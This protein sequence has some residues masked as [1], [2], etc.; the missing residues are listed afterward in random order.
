MVEP[1]ENLKSK[2]EKLLATTYSAPKRETVHRLR[3]SIRRA[4]AVTD[5][6]KKW[7]RLRRRAGRVRDLDVQSQLL[8]G[9]KLPG[10]ARQ[11]E[12]L[13]AM[14]EERQ[15]EAQKLVARLD[16]AHRRRL[17]RRL[18]RAPAAA[19]KTGNLLERFQAL[20]KRYAKL[21]ASNLHAFRKECK[22]LR[23]RA[24]AAGADELAAL[25][26]RIQDAIGAWHDW[27]ELAARAG[28]FLPPAEAAPLVSPL[29]EAVADHAATALAVSAAIRRELRARLRGEYRAGVDRGAGVARKPPTGAFAPGLTGRRSA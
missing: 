17:K 7:K 3:T 28:R 26:E 29:A 9:L 15:R 1:A 12:L 10:D 8:E 16:A 24:E 18:E 19:P 2:L 21:D 27:C 23:Y 25:F 5:V 13:K 6:G 20:D 22:Q 14:G 4:E 11:E